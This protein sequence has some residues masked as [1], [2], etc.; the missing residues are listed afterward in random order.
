[1]E[2]NLS[3]EDELTEE[4]MKQLMTG[5]K[6][7]FTDEHMFQHSLQIEADDDEEE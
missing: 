7:P 2:P 6:R 5:K 4:Q 3:M 1:M